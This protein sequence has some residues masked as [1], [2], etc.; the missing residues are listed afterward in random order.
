MG[1]ID[2]ISDAEAQGPLRQIYDA[3]KAQR[4]KVARIL[5]VH[6]LDPPA[7][8]QHLDLYIHLM[9]SPGP[10][11][12][13]ERKAIAVTVSAAKGCAY[14]VAHH[15]EALKRYEKDEV[16]L[17]A[18][19]D[20]PERWAIPRLRAMLSYARH[21]TGAPSTLDEAQVAALRVHGPTDQDI[22]PTNVITAC[23]NFVN[24]IALSLGVEADAEEIAGYHV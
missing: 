7:L 13:R 5:S 4:G 9:F 17:A 11:N 2:E 19:R 3:V 18:V 8:Q 14:C 1:W 10:L 15:L 6:S 21:L 16:A 22:P 20:A 24:R 12:R 23:V